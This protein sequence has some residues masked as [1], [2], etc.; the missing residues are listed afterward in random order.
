MR[1]FII[2]LVFQALY[3][4]DIHRGCMVDG[5]SRSYGSRPEL[6]E[7]HLSP[8]QHFM[9]HYDLIGEDK[10]VEGD[11]DENGI[12]DYVEQVGVI[13]DS[14]RQI[15]TEVMGFR[16]EIDDSDEKYD[17]YIVDLGSSFSA[18]YGWNYLD[19]S[20]DIEGTSWV[21]IDN[22]YVEPL[23][24]TNGLKAMRVTVAHEFFHAIQRAYH[25]K[26]TGTYIEGGGNSIDYGYFYEFTSMWI[27]DVIVPDG[28]DYLHFLSSSGDSRRFFSNPEQKFSDTDG[29]SVALF[30]HYLSDIVEDIE[31]ETLNTIIREVWEKFSDELLDPIDAFDSVLLDYNSS[32]I[33]SWVDFCSR[34]FHNGEFPDTDNNIYYYIDQT[35]V[36]LDDLGV[37]NAN[38]H[39]GYIQLAQSTDTLSLLNNELLEFELDNRSI[40]MHTVMADSLALLNMGYSDLLNLGKYII[41]ETGLSDINNVQIKDISTESISIPVNPNNII[42]FIYAN[43][44]SDIVD[45]DVTLGSIYFPSMPDIISVSMVEDGVEITWNPSDGQ[46]DLIYNIY[47]D[48]EPID[49]TLSLSYI[50]IT[51]ENETEYEYSISCSNSVGESNLSDGISILT[52]PSDEN[53]V[54]TKIISL[55]P[56]P[57]YR[58]GVSTFDLLVDYG[59]NINNID[60]RIYDIHGSEVLSKV[61]GGRSKG[62][63]LERLGSFLSS[64]LSS[65]IYFIHLECDDTILIQKFTVL[66]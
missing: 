38:L 66:K 4:E 20:D 25:E 39:K 2:I 59:S 60:F 11:E 63:E 28:N 43:S 48:G 53:V 58:P 47:R 27:E 15:L 5:D 30:G 10:V 44:N 1:F 37:E 23:Y 50:D 24:Y 29:Y 61:L 22:D 64:E 52:W 14:T 19:N 42:N 12:P 45:I 18:A 3:S 34:N 21:E 9:I 62:R 26:S 55:Y 17:I 32:F 7:I 13:A 65:G 33:E 51:I 46:G 40:E 35:S 56:N 41:A 31:D 6:S 8:S 36:V 49:S 54:A 57:I 16:S